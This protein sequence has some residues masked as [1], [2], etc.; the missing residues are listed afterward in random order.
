VQISVGG[1]RNENLLTNELA[2]KQTAFWGQTKKTAALL[3]KGLVAAVKHRSLWRH[4]PLGFKASLLYFR[5]YT[6]Y[7]RLRHPAITSLDYFYLAEFDEAACEHA[8][9]VMGWELPPGCRST[10]RADCN[11]V[12]M[13]NFMFLTMTGTT[14]LEAF[15][16][17]L[18][19]A[20]ALSRP[21]A[22]ARLDRQG[23]IDL[24]RLRPVCETMQLEACITERILA[25]AATLGQVR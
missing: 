21:A 15:L 25:A 19:R 20:D 24:E 6:P 18:V 8:L 11:F 17:N 7:L 1:T 22:L 2:A 14:Y 16:S 13:K 12:E 10:W 23:G 4:F 9:E 5:M 3:G